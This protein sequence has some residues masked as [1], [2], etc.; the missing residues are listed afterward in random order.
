MCLDI[1]HHLVSIQN[2]ANPLLDQRD[3]AV[4]VLQVSGVHP[5]SG[6]EDVDGMGGFRKRDHVFNL[7]LK[8]IVLSMPSCFLS[9]LHLYIR[10]G[11]GMGGSPRQF[12]RWPPGWESP[13][14]C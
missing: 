11:L 12:C 3:P 6:A 13:V 4:K 8:I 9:C 14:V 7:A 10:Q 2:Q 1:T 5:V